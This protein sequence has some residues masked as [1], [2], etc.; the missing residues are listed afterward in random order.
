MDQP[1]DV[2]AAFEMVFGVD[3]NVMISI[4]AATEQQVVL[5]VRHANLP[6]SWALTSGQLPEGIAF[7]EDGSLTGSALETGTF[8]LSFDVADAFGL[9]ASGA[10][11]LEVTVPV[12]GT[13]ALAAPFLLQEKTLTVAQELYLDRAGNSNGGYD[14]GDLRAYVL[15]NPGAPTA[16]QTMDVMPRRVPVFDLGP[17]GRP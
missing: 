1:R 9:R 7:S 11:T 4:P 3:P 2:T 15:A 12:I 5:E 16:S 13:T 14:L 10:V 8:P 17:G 6:A